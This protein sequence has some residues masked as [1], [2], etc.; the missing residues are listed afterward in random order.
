MARCKWCQH[1]G[2]RL[3]LTGNGLCPNC[4]PVVTPEIQQ[5]V[6]SIEECI[7]L[8]DASG[9]PAARLAK[10]N[11]L[12][13][14]ASILMA[15]E[16]RGIPT[17]NIKPSA[18]LSNYSARR[19]RL[20]FAT[21]TRE[22]EDGLAAVHNSINV[23]AKLDQLDKLLQ[24]IHSRMSE[25]SSYEDLVLLE[26]KVSDL[27]YRVRLDS[28]LED[29]RMSEVEGKPKKALEHYNEALEY[30]HK[31]R[32]DESLKRASIRAVSDK[33]AELSA[34]KSMAVKKT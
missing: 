33:I 1:F 18:L 25:T 13:D 16:R 28:F 7:R 15:Y 31:N 30:L 20:E 32:T 4:A 11:L 3:R 34:G 22:V 14:H 29:A 26:D 21:F 24:R 5:H 23:K 10:C 8:I 2:L 19:D 9:N 27:V 17:L 12:L 6:K